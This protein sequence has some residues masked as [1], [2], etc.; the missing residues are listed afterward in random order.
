MNW[1]RITRIAPPEELLVT[2]EEAKRQLVIGHDD[3]DE[4]IESLIDAATAAIDG[5]NGIGIAM[6]NQSFR[7]SAD[8]LDNTA[9]H[10]IPLGPVRSITSATYLDQDGATVPIKV[11]LDNSRSP[12]RLYLDAPVFHAQEGSIA[13]DFI[14]GYGPRASDVPADLRHAVLCLINA[15]Y[16]DR[17]GKNGLPMGV[18]TVL[19]RYRVAA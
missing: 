7:L 19:R 3:E 15:M 14:A 18:E 10:R 6:L 12:A 11:R 16:E 8:R 5:P 1:T 13:I 4:F 17:E 9:P 2:L